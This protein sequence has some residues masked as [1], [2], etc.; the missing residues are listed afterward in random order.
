MAKALSDVKS[1]RNITFELCA[2]GWGNVENFGPD[3]GHLWRTGP[4][5]SDNWESVMWNLG[6]KL[7]AFFQ[8]PYSQIISPASIITRLSRFLSKNQA[9]FRY[10]IH[11]QWKCFLSNYHSTERDFFYY[12]RVHF[13]FRFLVKVTKNEKISYPVCLFFV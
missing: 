2:W 10:I 13:I 9:F 7:S 12:C 1:I 3:F 5:V 8:I 11:I 6:Q 4:D